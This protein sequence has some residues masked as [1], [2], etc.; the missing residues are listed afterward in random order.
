MRSNRARAGGFLKDYEETFRD[1]GHG[2]YLD[3]GNGF[4]GVFMCRNLSNCMISICTIYCTPF[5][6]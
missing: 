3:Y 6:A 2:H 4:T 1:D 5:I